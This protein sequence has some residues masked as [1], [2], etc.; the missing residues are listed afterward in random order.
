MPPIAFSPLHKKKYFQAR[1]IHCT[2][3]YVAAARNEGAIQAKNPWLAFLDSD[4]LW[5]EKKLNEQW[6]Y[7]QKRPHLMACHCAEEWIKKGKKLKHPSHLQAHRG[8]FLQA[9]LENCL[10][11]CSALLIKKEIF[12]KCGSFDESFEVCEDFA[13][14]LHYLK[15][16]PIGLVQDKLVIKRSGSWPQ[17]SQK[18]H[19]LDSFRIQA[20]LKFLKKHGKDIKA[21][22]RQKA[23]ESIYKKLTILQ[24]GAK[25]HQRTDACQKF[26]K[27]QKEIDSLFQ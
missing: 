12:Q 6:N 17:L 20:I 24:E 13:F 22:E 5:T 23:K 7:L 10:L 14:C 4:D 21:T 3:P 19:S 8:K 16:Y 2:R 15:R 1:S 27:M 18:Y 26:Q 11:S 25:R 9:A